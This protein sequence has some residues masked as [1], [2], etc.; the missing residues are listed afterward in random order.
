[1]TSDLRSGPVKKGLPAS[2]TTP[3]AEFDRPIKAGGVIV[4][5]VVGERDRDF[6]S[7]VTRRPKQIR[8]E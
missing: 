8:V 6:T 2:S 5:G 1:L 4:R 7:Y 3:C